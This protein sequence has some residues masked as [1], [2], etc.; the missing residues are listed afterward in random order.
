MF[1]GPFAG[2]A[3]RRS[4]VKGSV[5]QQWSP[6]T[7]GVICL[8]GFLLVLAG[9]VWLFGPTWLEHATLVG[10]YRFTIAYA[11][12]Q[13]A[14]L[15]WWPR[16]ERSRLCRPAS[17]ATWFVPVF[18][19]GVESLDHLLEW[20]WTRGMCFGVPRDWVGAQ[21]IGSGAMLCAAVIACLWSEG[22]ARRTGRGVRSATWSIPAG[23]AAG[24]VSVELNWVLFYA[25]WNGLMK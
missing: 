3:G 22:I 7:I 25:V 12:C 5:A 10:W 18:I 17:D 8:G 14:V 9:P 6:I 21:G 15:R 20:P 24:I 4:G 2:T 11:S 1:G 13:V 16:T 19:W 23:V